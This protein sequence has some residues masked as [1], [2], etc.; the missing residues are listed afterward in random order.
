MSDTL[1][2]GVGRE[3]PRLSA[4]V[5]SNEAI[6]GFG[7]VF[8]QA[9]EAY[10]DIRPSYPE[11]LIDIAIQRGN[12]EPG[13]R[14][15]EVGSGTGKLTESL[16]RR[17]L[18]VDAVEPG[19]NMIA[20]AERRLG[21]T[22]AVT[23]HLGR[24]E[25]VSLPQSAFDA[26]FSASAF[27]WVDPEVGWAKAASL[28]RADG[29]LALLTHRTL[30][31]EQTAAFQ[32]ELLAV[33]RKHAPDV[34]RVWQP[35]RELEV[36]LEGAWERRA[37]VSDVWDWLMMEGQYRVAAPAA[38]D[39]FLDV[40]VATD[41]HTVEETADDLIAH[42]RTTSLYHRIGPALRE[43]L[44]HDDRRVFERFGGSICLSVAA[45]LMIARRAPG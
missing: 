20:S 40:E 15:L 14:V 29:V 21:S 5:D 1:I 35:S 38:A 43:A 16:V 33:L 41:V 26:V 13:S 4:S 28:L 31:D 9:A 23:F 39:L 18:I 34:A 7:Q 42:F 25:D 6:R 24:F 45:V 30:R 27:H 2:R 10:D 19:S 22:D 32:D 36:L 17:E 11:S 44:E 37:N 12:L 3:R 8:D